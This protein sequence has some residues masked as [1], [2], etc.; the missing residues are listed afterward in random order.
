MQTAGSR[1]SQ[2]STAERPVCSGGTCLASALAGAAIRRASRKRRATRIR[3]LSGTRA[4]SRT[5][6]FSGLRLRPVGPDVEHGEERVLRHFD[7][8]DLLHALLALLLALEQLA[9][10]G[11]VAA[12]A[13]GGHVLA[14]GLHGLAGD[15]VRADG[16]LDGDVVLLAR[17]AL[18][19]LLGEV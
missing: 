16:R 5:C 7:A 18:A 10:A 8:A 14:I 17:D 12:V 9:L 11:D 13:F 4:F 19:Q 3:I 1:A 6:G 15:D 2:P